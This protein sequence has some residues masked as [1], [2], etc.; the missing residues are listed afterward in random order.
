MAISK[1]AL[2]MAM[3]EAISEE[4]AHVPTDKS[5]IE[6][7]FSAKFEKKMSKLLKAQRNSYWHFYNTASKRVAIVFAVL[8]MLVTAACSV[9]EI[10]EP[11]VNFNK[12]VYE[13]FIEY[14]YEGDTV[15]SITKKYQIKELPEGF[16]QTQ[17]LES[18][19][20]ISITY[21]NENGDTIIFD[22]DAT[23]ASDFSWDNEHGKICSKRIG[24][25]DV[26]IY[27]SDVVKQ[28]FWLKD[29]YSFRIA[30]LGKLEMELL[31]FLILQVE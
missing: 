15:G 22:Q 28:A 1:E 24:S 2:K 27:E 17:Y 29:G 9:E 25:L 14:S 16:V 12:K 23:S 13:T 3:R 10:R 6:Y 20:F 5:A 19:A 31:E 8:V 21:E 30:C 7:K 26:E 4:F 11:I 18:D